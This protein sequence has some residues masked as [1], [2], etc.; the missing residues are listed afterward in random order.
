M[1]RQKHDQYSKQFLAELLE[2]QMHKYNMKFASL[3]LI[4]VYFVPAPDANFQTLGLL[5]QI[6]ARPCIIEPYRNQ[7]M[8]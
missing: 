3:S 6:A 4:I 7:P 8:K 2:S 1:T 5:G